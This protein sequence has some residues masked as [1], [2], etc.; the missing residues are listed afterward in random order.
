MRKTQRRRGKR[1]WLAKPFR[2]RTQPGAAPGTVAADPAA[3]APQ[4]RVIGYGPDSCREEPIE[5]LDRLPEVLRQHRVTWID[6]TGLGDADVIRRLGEIF[7]LHPLALEDVVN[8]HQRPKVDDYGEHLYIVARMIVPGP[9]L[10]TEQVS[11]FLGK[12]FLLTFQERPGDC[13]D[14][15]RKR[16]RT[17]KGRIRQFGPDFLAY[18][19]LDAVIDA[20]FP[21]LESIGERLDQL[22]DK[23]YTEAD[24]DTITQVHE[25]KSDLLQL[26]RTV[27]PLRD[28]LSTLIREPDPLVG[29]ETRLFL[30]DCHDHVV[31]VIDLVQVCRE[32][33]SD[34]RDVYLS[35]INNRMS[36][37][38]KVLTVIATIFIPLSFIAGLYG[39]NFDPNASPWNMPELRW[40]F[41][42]P[43][44]LGL[45]AAVAAGLLWF[46]WRRRW[47]GR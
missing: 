41:G 15:V 40:R 17:S 39:M 22:D 35:T 43:Y 26:R 2:R 31:Q 27:W 38:M 37:V 25:L 23:V 19:I 18:T 34:L 4:I 29:E 45:M 46:F 12:D 28:A 47:I 5:D 42:Y 36:E 21:V 9:R 1:R 24:R 14:P 11:I 30:R 16:I 20:Y 8:T 3:A 44:A 7:D 6:V 33:C 10:E 13:F 32:T